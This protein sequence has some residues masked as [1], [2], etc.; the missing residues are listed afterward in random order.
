A[1]VAV[2]EACAG[3]GLRGPGPNVIRSRDKV[4]MREVWRERGLPGPEFAPVRS[5]ADLERAAERLRAPFLLK[6][7]WLAGSQGQV[8]VGD[9]TDLAAV[10]R[11]VTSVVAE[12][13]QARLYAFM[14]TGRGAQFMAEAIS[15]ATTDSR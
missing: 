1:C 11:R 6:P 14:P 3:L 5:Q 2:A 4:E 9:D 13:D 15:A 8:L 7:T 10:W 12:L